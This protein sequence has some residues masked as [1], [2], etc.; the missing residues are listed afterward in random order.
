MSANNCPSCG[1]PYYCKASPGDQCVCRSCK[2]AWVIPDGFSTDFSQPGSQLMERVLTNDEL[3]M[4]PA[5]TQAHP[6]QEADGSWSMHKYWLRWGEPLTPYLAFSA[7]GHHGGF[8]NQLFQYAF[9]RI[10]AGMLHRQLLTPP[11]AGSKLF[12]IKDAPSV[13][14][15]PH[16]RDLSVSFGESELR[17]NL[18]EVPP[19]L[20]IAGYFQFQ[21]KFYAEHR[22]QIR[23]WFK[24]VQA[25]EDVF[26]PA[27]AAITEGGER[28]LVCIQLRR[29]N[30][31]KG[32][33]FIPS[34]EV[35]LD[36][37]YNLWPKLNKPVLYVASDRLDEVLPAFAPYSPKS[38]YDFKGSIAGMEWFTD[39][40]AM[41]Q[42]Q[43]LAISNS[44]FGVWAAMLNYRS[45]HK[46]VMV[47]ERF[48]RPRY[49]RPALVS[50]DP[51][52]CEPLTD[53]DQAWS[54]DEP[55][56]SKPHQVFD[57]IVNG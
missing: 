27:L 32:M 56:F 38:A 42:A 12:G 11:W 7:L 49:S 20:D 41:M 40:Y 5:G 3:A 6:Y 57:Q 48:W 51:W 55:S 35:Y 1:V 25:I 13:Q 53:R 28:T 22:D 37:L 14:A 26:A 4:Y 29:V 17:K 16:F 21:T 30:Y 43:Y 24:P 8:G 47:A 15:Y 18:G 10:F 31:G 19:C 34:N 2:L 46:T 9:A 44:T 23:E 45:F 52:D 54:E 33:F 50:F 39:F 36:W